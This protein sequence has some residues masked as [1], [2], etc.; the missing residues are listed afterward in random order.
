MENPNQPVETRVRPWW[1][2][3]IEGIIGIM[4]GGILLWAPAKTK[5]DT[6]MILVI[7]LGIY[8][9]VS[10]IFTIGRLSQNRK[11]WGWKLFTGILSILA[12][13]YILIYPAAAAVALPSVMVLVLG[14]WGVIHGSIRLLMAVQ[15]GGWGSAVLGALML[16]LGI[17]L[18]I[19]WNTPTWGL[20]LLY[21]AAAII[22][23]GGF[24]LIFQSFRHKPVEYMYQ[25]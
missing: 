20:S 17:V 10:G 14:I 11:Q 24:V 5:E 6:W 8:W 7:I 15:G 23:V 12:G 9:L 13:G 4:L 19:N 16:F 2:L 25:Y 22:F 3:F 18:I 1:L 21:V